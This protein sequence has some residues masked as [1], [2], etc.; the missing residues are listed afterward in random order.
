VSLTATNSAA[1]AMIAATY[2]SSKSAN[3]LVITHT[4]T[5]GATFD[6]IATAN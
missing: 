6:I 2:V 5:S 4:G 1:A 3:T